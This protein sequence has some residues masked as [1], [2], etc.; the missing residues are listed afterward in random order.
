LLGAAIVGA[1]RETSADEVLGYGKRIEVDA[2]S[3]KI[4]E[5]ELISR[6]AVECVSRSF[7]R[8]E[9]KR[10]VRL[11]QL[12]RNSRAS[13][14]AKNDPFYEP[15]LLPVVKLY[16][17]HDYYMTCPVVRYNILRKEVKCQTSKKKHCA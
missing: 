15:R 1:K 12:L 7:C 2:H 17:R 13:S 16:Y 11:T 14:G 6:P 4:E 5:D 8:L 9:D 10:S 3:G